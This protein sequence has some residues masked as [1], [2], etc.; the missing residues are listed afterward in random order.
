MKSFH[1]RG[2]IDE[3]E[4]IDSPTK[5]LNRMLSDSMNCYLVEDLNLGADAPGNLKPNQ[6]NPLDGFENF[7][8]MYYPSLGLSGTFMVTGIEGM[9]YDGYV[10]VDKPWPLEIT[11]EMTPFDIMVA[12]TQS[13]ANGYPDINHVWFEDMDID[14]DNK[15]IHF[16]MGS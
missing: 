11:P 2:R 13:E 14:E 4:E 9:Y 15:T 6:G 7:I 16:S 10:G 5:L 12:V 8:K 1:L 3:L